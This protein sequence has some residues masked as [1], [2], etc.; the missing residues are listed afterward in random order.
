MQAKNLGLK[1][2]PQSKIN[3]ACSPKIRSLCRRLVMSGVAA[4]QVPKVIRM[5]TRAFGVDPGPLPNPRSVGRFI[6]EGGA[7]AKIQAGNI[8]SGAQ[9]VT[10]S[11]DST[12][13]RNI[14]FS[15]M[16]VMVNS[17]GA[18]NQ[19]YLAV[20]STTDHTSQTQV[21]VLKA[22]L[23]SICDTTKRAPKCESGPEATPCTSDIACKLYGVNGD[24]AS[25]QL[26][27]A[28]L[29][30]EWKIDSWVNRLGNQALINLGSLESKSLYQMIHADAEAKAGGSDVFSALSMADKEDLLASECQ[31]QVW[32]LGKTEFDKAAPN[33]QQDMPCVVRGGCCAHKD[34]N[35]AKGGATAMT[36]FWKANSHLSSPVKL[37]NKDN[38]ATVSLSDPS[39]EAMEAEQRAVAITESGAI[40]LC[41]L[42][43]A[44]YNHKD[45]KKGHQDS[46][47]YW[48]A[49]KHN[50]F[51]RFPDT[52]NVRYSSYIDA[53]TE[54]CTFHGAYIDYMEHMRKQ[55]ASGTLNHLELNLVK[56]LNCPATL[57][58]LLSISLYGQI[59]SKPYMRLV[60]SATAAG[61]G[62]ADLASLHTLVQSHL[63][64]I[65]ANPSL[66][67]GL[68]SAERSATLDGTDWENPKVLEALR[69]HESKLPYL[70]DLFVAFCQ[71]TLQTWT[72]FT[73]EFLPGGS[74]A[75]LT[76]EQQTKAF[77][78]PTNDANEGALG[79]WR[80]WARRF[81]S[82][83]LHK[84][85]AITMN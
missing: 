44:A 80:V 33:I 21:K 20:E 26:K 8:L 56:A 48:F 11:M 7:A 55:R 43:G 49:E 62:L 4:I 46:H 38:D 12:S 23:D 53:A 68:K 32:A 22:T 50:R 31:K 83:T 9:G 45:D 58:E 29:E 39:S 63:Q 69:A 57:G 74:I 64:S 47:A 60:R 17:P 73:D 40:K 51:Q 70:P 19:L 54:L 27:V 34:M 14:N 72:R 30:K 76:P 59:I 16:H 77:M 67:L 3:G 42:A 2:V 79:T 15:S 25:D 82:L 5:C 85:N 61:R 10:T 75:S 6:L 18:H 28:Q 37:F 36:A 1:R 78:P 35:A 13:H 66:L 52:S 65:I 81:P 84:F 71:G 24:H 41:S